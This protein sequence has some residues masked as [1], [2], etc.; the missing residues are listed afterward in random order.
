[1]AKLYI[2]TPNYN[3]MKFLD[4]YFS[5]LFSQTFKDF[6]IVF[7]ENSPD[8]E[9]IDYVKETFPSHLEKIIFIK[10]P[11]NYGF[12]RGNNVGIQRALEDDECE[13]ILCLNN[14]TVS[15][16]D[17]LE[18]LVHCAEKHPDAGSIQPLIIWGKNHELI[19]SVGLEYSQNGLGFNRG[20]YRPIDEYINE[21]EIFGC[22][23]G[24]CLYRKDA[25]EDIQLHHEFFDEDFFAYFEDIDLALR[26]RWAGWSAWFTP[27]ARVYHYSGGTAGDK[28]DFSVYHTWRNYTWTVA[29]NLPSNYIWRKFYLIILSELSQIALHILRRKP[30]IFK[31]KWDAYRNRGKFTSKGKMIKKSVDFKEVEKWFILKWR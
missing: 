24:A 20:A 21:E 17:F 18:N 29:K 26:L 10:N 13:Y 5:S 8:C 19:D 1:M 16:S 2:I 6:K 23:A 27:N 28:T 31:A 22:C 25:L 14:D 4:E 30:V 3:G 11:E 12:A 15:T 9:S 7:V